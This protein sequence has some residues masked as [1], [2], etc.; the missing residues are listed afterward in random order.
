MYY[1]AALLYF[2]VEPPVS[3]FSLT[4]LL[5]SFLFVNSWSPWLTPTVPDRWMVV[6]G[7]WSIG[8]EFT[9]YMIFP[10][11]ASRIRSYRGALIG[12]IAA[13]ILGMAA[14]SY[15]QPKLYGIYGNIA[16]DNFLYFWFPNQLPIFMLGLV[17]YYIIDFFQKNQEIA[18]ISLIRH[19]PYTIITV[20]ALALACFGEQTSYRVGIFSLTPLHPFPILMLVSLIFVMFSLVLFLNPSIFLINRVICSLGEVSFSAYLLHFMVLHE[21]TTRMPSLFDLTATGFGAIFAGAAL[22]GA[23]VPITF[24]LSLFTFNVIEAPMIRLGRRM[25]ERWANL[26]LLRQARLATSK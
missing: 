9:F 20:C 17:L 2:I 1:L 5:G 4:Q 21:L 14:N 19:W 10:L 15:A 24:G 22:W 8:V 12:F 25:L 3:G 18:L 23:T 16:T 13:I 26:R 11:L 7:G 6:P